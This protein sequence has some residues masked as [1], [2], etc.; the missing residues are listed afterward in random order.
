M[1]IGYI[2]NGN[3]PVQ[4]IPSDK[5]PAAFRFSAAEDGIELDN[6]LSLSGYKATA[7][8]CDT[9]GVVIAKV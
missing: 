2:H 4:W 8:Y 9:C 6:K 3:Q 1:T 7:H 5:K